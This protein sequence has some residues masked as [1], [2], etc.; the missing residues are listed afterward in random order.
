MAIITGAHF[1][2]VSKERHVEYACFIETPYQRAPRLK[3][4]SGRSVD[5]DSSLYE[6]TIV[7]TLT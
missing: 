3:N 6:G 2:R 4:Q 7:E 5:P 1:G